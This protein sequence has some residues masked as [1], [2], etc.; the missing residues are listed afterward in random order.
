M[1]LTDILQMAGAL[2]G[3]IVA[4]SLMIMYRNSTQDV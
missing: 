1:T 2:L 3:A 4:V